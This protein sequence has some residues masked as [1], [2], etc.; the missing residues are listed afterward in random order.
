MRIIL[1]NEL[2]KNFTDICIFIWTGIRMLTFFS[3]M[4]LHSRTFYKVIKYHILYQIHKIQQHSLRY[5]I[6]FRIL[7]NFKYQIQP[8]LSM[9]QGGTFNHTLEIAEV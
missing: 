9:F 6:Y 7:V 3:F 8:F 4:N 2:S 1:L 5:I